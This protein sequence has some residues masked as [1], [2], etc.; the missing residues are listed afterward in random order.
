MQWS[1]RNKVL[2]GY[3][4]MLVLTVVVGVLGLA[5]V[6]TLSRELAMSSD[7]LAP[8]LSDAEDIGRTI[9]AAR[10]TVDTFL[11]S[12]TRVDRQEV[13]RVSRVLAG[14]Y[15]TLIADLDRIGQ[16]QPTA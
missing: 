7:V 8:S 16:R 3:G 15:D 12:P 4:L 14:H 9:S 1:L 11:T 2:G 10:Q 13:Q 6:N 5:A